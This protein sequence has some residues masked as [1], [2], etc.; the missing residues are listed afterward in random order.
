MSMLFSPP[1]STS[2]RGSNISDECNPAPGHHHDSNQPQQEPTIFPAATSPHP[3][4]GD[5][6]NELQQRFTNRIQQ[7]REPSPNAAK[8]FYRPQAPR[9]R[10]GLPPNQ[11]LKDNWSTTT[12]QPEPDSNILAKQESTVQEGSSTPDSSS[13]VAA[14]IAGA[15]HAANAT[16]NI[17]PART[18]N[19]SRLQIS[20]G[21]SIPAWVASPRV[22]LVDDDEVSRKLFSKF[23]QVLGCI[24]DVA[25]DGIG[26]VNKMNLETYDLVLM[27][28]FM[29]KLNGVQ[30][31]SIIR[32]SDHMTPIISMTTNP[33]P[34]D[35]ANYSLAGMNDILSKPFTRESLSLVLEKHLER[36]KAIPET[37]SAAAEPSQVP[38]GDQSLS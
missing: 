7:V 1:F 30:A 19:G 9:L 26:G 34:D 21:A 27:D 35:I 33:Q 8:K 6:R 16:D 22:L 18:S 12:V 17:D 13:S 24:V 32:Q 14:S 2:N 4:K 28:I 36:L 23:L 11:P 38:S 15:S 20:K 25:V 10:Q 37:P 31:T 29:P 5:Q 3:Q